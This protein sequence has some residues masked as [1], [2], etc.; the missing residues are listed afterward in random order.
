[1]SNLLSDCLFLLAGMRNLQDDNQ[2]QIDT[3]TTEVTPEE[4]SAETPSE[5]PVD[6]SE[7]APVE[8]SEEA[9]EE[10]TEATSDESKVDSTLPN[11]GSDCFGAPT[12]L[13]GSELGVEFSD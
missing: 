11:L 12:A 13:A 2:E 6:A 9:T 4:T 10:T 8:T 5:T 7:E 3:E 1:M